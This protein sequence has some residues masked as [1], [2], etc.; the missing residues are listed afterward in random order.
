MPVFLQMNQPLITRPSAKNVLLP[1]FAQRVFFEPFGEVGRVQPAK[2][3]LV[4]RP[5][6][7]DHVF[8]FKLIEQKGR[9][10]GDDQLTAPGN[11]IIEAG[12][13]RAGLRGLLKEAT[14]QSKSIGVQAK[15][16]FIE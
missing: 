7:D 9:L 5:L 11:K 4:V 12:S 16:G 10:S 1:K 15:L 2:C 13:L 3:R 6:D 14:K 8:P